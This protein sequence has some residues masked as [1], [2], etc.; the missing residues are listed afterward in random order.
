LDGFRWQ[1]EVSGA[2]GITTNDRYPTIAMGELDIFC[3]TWTFLIK[4]I[5]HHSKSQITYA[6]KHAFGII[7]SSTSEAF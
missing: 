3:F 6:A 7:N 5:Q 2:P 4:G 1:E